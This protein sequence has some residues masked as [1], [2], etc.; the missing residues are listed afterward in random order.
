MI[1]GP[2]IVVIV[3]VAL[4]LFGPDKV[5]QMLKTVKKAIGLYAEARDQV[6]EVVSTQIISPEE[7]ELLKD[8][9]GIKGDL[10]S[11]APVNKNSLLT[12][13]RQSLYNQTMTPPPATT[14]ATPV[15]SAESSEALPAD[16]AVIQVTES[17]VEP[18]AEPVT[19]VTESAAGVAAVPMTSAESIWAS[20]ESQ[21]GAPSADAPTAVDSAADNKGEA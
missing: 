10:K 16:G 14:S 3:I 4:V 5:P 2:E 15:A 6:Q 21:V 13:E 1:G 9:L 7:L 19:V 12:P 8:P 17:A 11:G 18:G 20:L